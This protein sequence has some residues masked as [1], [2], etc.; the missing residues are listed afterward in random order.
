MQLWPKSLPV[1][2]PESTW[3]CKNHYDAAG[4]LLEVDFH[5]FL[6]LLPHQLVINVMQE[7]QEAQRL[8]NQ[9]RSEAM[10]SARCLS[11]ELEEQEEESASQSVSDV[12]AEEQDASS[13][14]ESVSSETD[15][16][17]EPA[18]AMDEDF[19]DDTEDCPGKR[20][21]KRQNRRK[22]KHRKKELTTPYQDPEAREAAL[23][24]TLEHYF[25]IVDR[26]AILT[27]AA[28]L[29]TGCQ[30]CHNG[31]PLFVVQLETIGVGFNL[32]L[33]CQSGHSFSFLS[34]ALE[35]TRQL[36][37]AN[38]L[39]G[40]DPNSL[41]ELVKAARLGT[42]PQKMQ[43]KVIKDF[44]E[45]VVFPAEEAEQERLVLAANAAVNSRLEAAKHAARRTTLLSASPTVT[46]CWMNTSAEPT[47]QGRR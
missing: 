3:C 42:A 5:V 28:L 33:Q 39:V 34:A 30:E 10:Q 7:E 12:E 1:R 46:S 8:A 13:L 36:V 37:A 19:S 44:A 6:L 38:L 35:C 41:L 40:C 21:S 20:K 11:I 23:K 18:T 4:L 27:L 22:A 31:S 32:H 29:R 14:D 17:V 24:L 9:R 2:H 47:L 43:E 26:S 25:S 16:E 15:G 45:N